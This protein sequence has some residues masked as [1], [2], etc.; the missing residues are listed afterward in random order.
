MCSDADL[1]ATHILVLTEEL[2]TRRNGAR[3]NFG[4]NLRRASSC[5]QH[6]SQRLC[7]ST[8]QSCKKN[9]G[10][11]T[12]PPERCRL[13]VHAKDK[14]RHLR[15]HLRTPIA[16]R[17]TFCHNFD[18]MGLSSWFLKK[19]HRGQKLTSINAHHDTLT[20]SVITLVGLT[21]SSSL[22]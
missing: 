3:G 17:L 16:H 12:H 8:T 18:S 15:E 21:P 4:G 10:K 6:I 22:V 11:S 19:Q 5:I 13:H 2:S 1:T 9:S 20:I 14:R 7:E